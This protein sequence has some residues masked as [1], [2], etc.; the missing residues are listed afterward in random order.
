MNAR[1]KCDAASGGLLRRTARFHWLVVVL[2][3]VAVCFPNLGAAGL[4]S[5]EGHRAIPGWEAL[6]KGHWLPTTMFD[7]VYVRKPPGMPWAVAVSSMV[8]GETEFAA[9]LP[10]ALSAAVMSFV[11]WLFAARW[12]GRPWGIAAGLAQA[13]LPRLWPASRTADIEA[14]LCLGVQVA[15]FAF[16]H[17][18]VHRRETRG[19]HALIWSCIGAGGLCLA[20][21]AKA[22]AGLPVVAGVIAA[23]CVVRRSARVALHPAAWGAILLAAAALGPIAYPQARAMRS[24]AAV[25]EDFAKFLWSSDRVLEWLI[26]PFAV[27]LAGMPASLALLFPWGPDARRECP[28]DAMDDRP[29]LLGVARCLGLAF[30]FSVGVYMLAGVTNDRYAMPALTLLPPMAAYVARG[31]AEFLTERRRAIARAFCLGSPTV[32]LTGLLVGAGVF[33]AVLEPRDARSSAR[34]AAAGLA[35]ALPDGAT[36]WAD[37]WINA[38]PELVWYAVRGAAAEGRRATALWKRAEIAKGV[39]PTEG[40]LLLLKEAEA[41]RYEAA[42]LGGR[43]DILMKGEAD[44]TP[45]GLYVVKAGPQGN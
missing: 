16:I 36:L 21:L 20:L 1:H 30:L 32:V 14:L 28:G 38:K 13:L 10:S 41:A 40:T 17:A 7:A 22:H 37:A 35:G 26:F 31:A 25:V 42:G 18:L 43:L 33:V 3:S 24:E 15:A 29:R 45:F 5:T 8:F 39:L 12:F 4:R 23:A 2:V 11:A 34:P 44:G 27:L 19:R 6:D 9:R